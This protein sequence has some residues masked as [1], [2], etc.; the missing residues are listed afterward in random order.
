MSLKYER[1]HISLYSREGFDNTPL[2]T[3]EKLHTLNNISEL[4]LTQLRKLACKQYIELE[5][6]TRNWEF[7]VEMLKKKRTREI[8]DLIFT[9][10]ELENN[11][12]GYKVGHQKKM[13][14]CQKQRHEFKKKLEEKDQEYKTIL[15]EHEKK[16]EE[17][18][19]EHK[20]MLAEH[21]KKLTEKE[22]ECKTMLAEKDEY[23]SNLFYQEAEKYKN[24]LIQEF[25]QRIDIIIKEKNAE[26]LERESAWELIRFLTSNK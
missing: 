26:K 15:A 10:K 24:S 19:E 14:E 4:N 16:L 22:E 6:R 12:K 2:G 21:E 7:D 8:S 18:E 23:C 1:E 17:K 5:R 25:E 20:T 3:N 9:K 13:T 11:L